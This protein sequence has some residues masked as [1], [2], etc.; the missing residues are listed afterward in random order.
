ML[1][2]L[3]P[4]ALEFMSQ[5]VLKRQCLKFDPP[6]NGKVPFQGA[7]LCPTLS[8]RATQISALWH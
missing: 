6:L 4:Q 1:V 3:W 2:F 7:S 5:A 8:N